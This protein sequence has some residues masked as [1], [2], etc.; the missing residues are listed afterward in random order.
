MAELGIAVSIIEI[1][2][3]GVGLSRALYNYADSVWSAD[4]RLKAVADQVE[5]TSAVI[6]ELDDIFENPSTSK[7]IS[8]NARC[9]AAK[10]LDKC[11]IVFC[12]ING[13]VL[14]GRKPLGKILFGIREHRLNVFKAELEEL[15]DDL[16]L[17][18]LILTHVRPLK[19]Q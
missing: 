6:K 18:M 19:C 5:L 4:R 15:K 17:L 1:V 11:Y 9:T 7:L 16:Q 13:M 8:N 14:K 3:T 2:S 12:D 10:V